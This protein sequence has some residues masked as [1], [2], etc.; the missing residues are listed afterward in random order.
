MEFLRIFHYLIHSIASGFEEGRDIL[1]FGISSKN[2]SEE[3]PATAAGP[4]FV[5]DNFVFL[6]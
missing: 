1:F 3:G 4:F 5:A 6:I 2:D